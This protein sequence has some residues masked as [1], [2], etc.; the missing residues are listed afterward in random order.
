MI[1]EKIIT[2]RN[3]LTDKELISKFNYL[4]D[5]FGI[6]LLAYMINYDSQTHLR[7]IKDITINSDQEQ[8]ILRIYEYIKILCPQTNLS[9]L[10]TFTEFIKTMS[11]SVNEDFPRVKRASNFVNYFHEMCASHP[12]HHAEEFFYNLP[13]KAEQLICQIAKDVFPRIIIENPTNVLAGPFMM[14][15]YSNK[16][17][18]ELLYLLTQDTSIEIRNLFTILPSIEEC[19]KIADQAKQEGKFFKD[20]IRNINVFFRN[21]HGFEYAID[22]ANIIYGIISNAEYD[23]TDNINT[24]LNV[25]INSVL[26]EFREF[27]SLLSENKIKTKVFYGLENIKIDGIKQIK[28]IRIRPMI[29]SDKIVITH[30]YLSKYDSGSTLPKS[31]ISAIYEEVIITQIDSVISIPRKFNEPD[32]HLE[33]N[34][35]RIIKE[36][37]D[38]ES[39]FVK[40]NTAFVL[41]YADSIYPDFIK[42]EFLKTEIRPNTFQRAFAVIKPSFGV[43]GGISQFIKQNNGEVY[44]KLEITDQVLSGAIRYLKQ[45]DTLSKDVASSL[46]ISMTRLISAIANVS[47]SKFIDSILDGVIVWENLLGSKEVKNLLDNLATAISIIDIENADEVKRLYKLRCDVAH[48]NK[49]MKLTHDNKISIY[50]DSQKILKISIDLLK[51]VINNNKLNKMSNSDKRIK[52]I[53]KGI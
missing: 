32:T 9:Q 17:Y 18:D 42:S 45:L 28:N 10:L 5:I 13:S 37:N 25:Y 48:G 40:I 7:N 22:F 6:R 24:D 3:P 46:E 1:P 50:T 2:E 30:D 47:N 26:Q 51:Y 12:E 11:I 14:G 33:K 44:P 52:D 19:Q 34:K 15:T 27:V 38:R 43:N 49:R 8:G 39:D 31:S 29:A 41:A 20:A 23:F 21:I 53:L 16:Q 4:K 36:F 35:N